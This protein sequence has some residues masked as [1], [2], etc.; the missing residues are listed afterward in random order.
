MFLMRVLAPPVATTEVVAALESLDGVSNVV[1]G[2]IT[3]DRGLQV[4]N[5]DV[6]T[7]AADSA[8]LVLEQ[9]GIDPDSVTMV[10]QSAVRPIERGRTSRWTVELR[11]N[12][13]VWA[14]AI[15]TARE[16]AVLSPR[17]ALLMVTAGVI[18]TF[19]IILRNP[20]LLVGAMATSPDLLPLSAFCIGVVGKRPRLAM[21]GLAILMIGMIIAGL[22]AWGLS[23]VM[24][25]AGAYNGVLSS[26]NALAGIVTSVSADT[27]LVALTAGA[28]G[29]L[30]FQS[31]ASSAVGVAI[32]VTTM[33]AVAFAGVAAGIADYERGLSALLVLLVNIVMLF[34]GGVLTLLLQRALARRAATR[35]WSSAPMTS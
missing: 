3:H 19:G 6:P 1:V 28:V 14:E 20:I 12:S 22:T 17:Y 26:G 11:A 33:P 24:L 4:I 30:A 8:F 13:L 34:L 25:H 18:A 2:G 21:R 35:A 31:R 29:M 27:I 23:W 32:S 16:N 15:E 5:A 7:Y 10:R 9:A